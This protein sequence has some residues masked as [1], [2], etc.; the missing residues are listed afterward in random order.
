MR[1]IFR[2]EE[3]ETVIHRIDPRVKLV[4]VF[5]ISVLTII[6]GVPW[7]LLVIFLSTLPFWILLHPSREKVNSFVFVLCTMVFGFMFSQS[8][9]YYW[10]ETP[11]FTII[12]AD[13]PVL[14]YIT[15]G[16]HV[17]TEGV[18]YGL[19]Q[20][21]RFMASVSA[22][23]VLVA[24]T[25]PSEL[26]TALVRFVRIGKRWIGFPSEIAFMVSSAAGFAPSMIEESI[27]T[28]NAMQARGLKMKGIT[29]KIKAMRYLLFPL[30]VNVLRTGRQI[31]IAADARAFRATK[32]RTYL[33]ELKLNGFDYIFLSYIF[34]FLSA[35]IY[36]SFTGYG[37]TAPGLGGK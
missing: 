23:M 14:G 4:W 11:A 20:S 15:G 35:G 28:T 30:V 36:L 37:S 9:F 6:A 19:I 12:S 18:V 26:I 22:A 24:S 1:A 34:V 3:K 10:G 17:Y 21:L 29:N 33:K 13:F 32:N 7:M 5:S 31:A 25:H 2:Y 27:I 16:L 8:I